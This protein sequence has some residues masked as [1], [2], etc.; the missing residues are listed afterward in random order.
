[1]NT[2]TMYSISGLSNAAMLAVRVENPPVP[3]VENDWQTASKPSIPASQSARIS[4]SVSRMY[5]FQ[6]ALVVSNTRGV[7]RC[8]LA[9]LAEREGF[10]PS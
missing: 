8:D 10:E 6:S 9:L 4:T 7:S 1:M 5:I 3:R 2:M